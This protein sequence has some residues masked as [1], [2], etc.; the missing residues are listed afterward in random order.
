MGL[1][2]ARPT[3]DLGV[4]GG[5]RGARQL[6][7]QR[8]DTQKEN[9]PPGSSGRGG[10]TGP[11]R[12]RPASASGRRGNSSSSGIRVENARSYLSDHVD[13]LMSEIINFLLL[14][15]PAEAENAILAFLEARRAGQSWR[16]TPGPVSRQ[17]VLRDRLYMARKVQPILEQLIHQV[18]DEQPR[19]VESHFIEVRV[20]SFPSF[21]PLCLPSS[22]A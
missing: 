11:E 14:E 13:P 19:D 15:Q 8:N 22:T 21:L 1:A 5:V 12:K 10:A 20:A 2:D 6:R 4:G 7:R 3:N 9:T 16:P 18:V 17:A